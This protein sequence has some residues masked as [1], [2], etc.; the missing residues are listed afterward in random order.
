MLNYGVRLTFYQRAL[1]Q[2]SPV[3]WERLQQPLQQ[4]AQ[5]GVAPVQ[6]Q[7]V[8]VRPFGPDLEEVLLLAPLADDEPADPVDPAVSDKHVDQGRPLEHS[9]CHRALS[10]ACWD[11]FDPRDR[12]RN[13]SSPIL[14]ANGQE[15]KR[16]LKSDPPEKNSYFPTTD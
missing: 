15:G 5:V 7:N 14:D 2:L 4:A 11:K 12:E 1:G 3:L 6:I 8:P 10:P 16:T 9:R 13:F